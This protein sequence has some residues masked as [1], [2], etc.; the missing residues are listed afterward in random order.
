MNKYLFLLPFIAAIIGWLANGLLIKLL[1]RSILPKRQQQIAEQIGKMVSKEF[2]FK[3]IEEKITNPASIQKIMPLV[4][5]HI[6]EFLRN[7]LSAAMPMLSMFIGDKTIAQLKEV[8]MKELE[9]MFPQ[10]LKNYVNNLQEDIDVEKIITEKIATFPINKLEQIANETMAK[11]LRFFKLVGAAIG[12]VIGLL[13][14]LMM[15][16]IVYT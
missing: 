2:S 5:V 3:Q 14:V 15:V 12:F 4:E 7:K 9:T 10:L 13:E 6:D 11:E 8:F 1:F 16:F